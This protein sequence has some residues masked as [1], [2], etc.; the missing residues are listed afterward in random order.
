MGI[1]IILSLLSPIFKIADVKTIDI[2]YKDISFD[3]YDKQKEITSNAQKDFLNDLYSK[4]LE[5]IIQEDLKKSGIKDSKTEIE[6]SKDDDSYGEIKSINISVNDKENPEIKENISK[7]L[8]VDEKNINITW[9][10]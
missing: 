9:E 3:D 7:L 1:I 2:P 8:D 6:F 5:E 10:D 4:R